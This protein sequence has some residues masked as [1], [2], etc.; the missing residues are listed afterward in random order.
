M[1]SSSGPSNPWRLLEMKT[2]KNVRNYWTKD[3]VSYLTDVNLQQHCCE[4]LTTGTS[5]NLLKSMLKNLRYAHSTSL[6]DE[7]CC[8]CIPY[9]VYKFNVIILL[10]LPKTCPPSTLWHQSNL[11]Y[12]HT[13]EIF[14]C[15]GRL[16]LLHQ[17]YLAPKINSNICKKFNIIYLSCNTH[18]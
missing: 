11:D 16:Q 9:C 15:S 4:N 14:R 1:P 18:M 2:L 13:A 10:L 5:L 8:Q 12:S 17:H 7:L 3:T 6:Q